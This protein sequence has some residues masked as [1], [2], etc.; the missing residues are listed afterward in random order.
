MIKNARASGFVLFTA[1]FF[2][3]PAV[4][5]GKTNSDPGLE[6]NSGQ[7]IWALFSLIIVV[8]LTYWGTRVLAGKFQTAQAKHLMVAESLFLGPN[9]YLYLILI[10]GK[11]FLIGSSEQNITLLKEIDD[12]QFYEELEK[13]YETNRVL[14]PRGFSDFL[15]PLINS[16]GT[17]GAGE[18]I[19]ANRKQRIHEGLAKIRHWK[20]GRDRDG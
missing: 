1:G 16:I 2:L 5:H 7:W 3:L 10:R 20:I 11:V 12:S 8:F 4:A 13:N 6:F 19:S 17:K 9:R 18:T 15:G 14:V